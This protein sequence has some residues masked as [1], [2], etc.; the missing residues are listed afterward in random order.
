MI[1][2]FPRYLKVPFS[3]ILP[4][5]SPQ[6]LDLIDRLLQFDPSKRIT[7]ADALRHPYFTSALPAPSS[8][9][10]GINPYAPS[11][12]GQQAGPPQA[13][14]GPG[15]MGPPPGYYAHGAHA[16]HNVPVQAHGAH[17]GHGGHAGHTAH[18]GPTAAPPG[19]GAQSGGPPG[20]PPTMYPGFGHSQNVPP[21]GMGVPAG[22][23]MTMANLASGMPAPDV[24][25]M[26]FQVKSDLFFFLALRN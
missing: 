3:Q 25:T 20:P 19:P 13:P 26:V 5:A 12:G 9:P 6:A 17:G 23:P 7:A 4:K 16:S 14:P 21:G 18:H 24:Q 11:P 10:Q 22:V 2:A 15:Q 8:I 1:K